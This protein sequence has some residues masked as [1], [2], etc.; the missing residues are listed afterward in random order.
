L[1]TLLRIIARR[2]AAALVTSLILMTGVSTAHAS[3]TSDV[4]ARVTELEADLR[5]LGDD[6][7]TAQVLSARASEA[8]HQSE[9]RVRRAEVVERK[10]SDDAHHAADHADEARNAAGALAAALSRQGLGTHTV[11][12]DLNPDALLSRLGTLDQLSKRASTIYAEAEQQSN[13]AQ[14]IVEQ[15]TAALYELEK[16]DTRRSEALL[17]AERTAT[18]AA[19]AYTAAEAESAALLAQLADLNQRTV[20]A[21]TAAQE[22]TAADA[23]LREFAAAQEAAEPAVART[24]DVPPSTTP[25]PAAPVYPAPDAID[26]DPVGP[27]IPTP[28][29]APAPAPTVSA[30]TKAISFARQQL[31]DRYEFGGSGPDSWDC[32]G[33]TKASYAV[34]GMNIGTHSASNQYA[35][36]KARGHLVSLADAERGDL[37]FWGS[38]GDYYHTAI[39][40]GS[41]QI[42]EAAN[43]S[44][45]VRIHTVWSA[46]QVAPL[47][48]RPS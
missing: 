40:L 3:E 27:V 39:Y 23:D 31:G 17:T 6:V 35:T 10:L 41:G 16:L 28:A 45:P 30:Q 19:H 37:L 26:P 42:L 18:S 44:V 8:A 47:V 24:P 9:E 43:P 29:P 4:T 46:S 12:F 20:K 38:G 36:L 1:D 2:P 33:L 22:K 48:G 15:S 13:V 34:A 11:F 14:D 7:R 32:S 25:Y 21:E 5:E